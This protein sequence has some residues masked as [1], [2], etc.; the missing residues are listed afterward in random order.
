[1]VLK[2]ETDIII[3]KIKQHM[4]TVV[5]HFNKLQFEDL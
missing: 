2:F 5:G 4:A 3:A 1:M